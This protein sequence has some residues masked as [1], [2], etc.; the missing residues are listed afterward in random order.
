MDLAGWAEAGV[1]GAGWGQQ[2]LQSMRLFAHSVFGY[3]P[4]GRWRPGGAITWSNRRHGGEELHHE[5]PPHPRGLHPSLLADTTPANST[6]RCA[7]HSLSAK[8]TGNLSYYTKIVV[9]LHTPGTYIL[10]L[11]TSLSSL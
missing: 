11:M 10:F 1:V 9:I 5:Q 2:T 7:C 3:A 8:C 4:G 6:E